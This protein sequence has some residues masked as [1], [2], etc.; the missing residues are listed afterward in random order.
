MKKLM[1]TGLLICMLLIGAKM[2][3]FPIKC[4]KMMI[5]GTEVILIGDRHTGNYPGGIKGQERQINEINVMLQEWIKFLSHYGEET[6]FLLEEGS[7][8]PGEDLSPEYSELA[9]K[10]GNSLTFLS[11]F[12]E[13]HPTLGCITFKK[14]DRRTSLSTQF[15]LFEAVMIKVAKDIL[16]EKDP[17]IIIKELSEIKKSRCIDRLPLLLTMTILKES[18]RRLS[19]SKSDRRGSFFLKDFPCM[20]DRTVDS[21]VDRKRRSVSVEQFL[22][23]LRSVVS[24]L[25]H[26]RINLRMSSQYVRLKGYNDFCT[27]TISLLETFLGPEDRKR[28]W[29][30]AI[31]DSIKREQS[32][33]SYIKLNPVCK[34]E[35]IA[36]Y[37][38]LMDIIDAIER[39]VRR[40]VLYAGAE[41]TCNS[42]CDLS[43]TYGEMGRVIEEAGT[44][45]SLPWEDEDFSDDILS[46]DELRR[47]LY[48]NVIKNK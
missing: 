2:H 26:M 38:F 36:D 12:V 20:M 45:I 19:E 4:T 14:A 33:Q 30:S 23:D 16:D 29:F 10:R 39:D 48:S 13:R 9:I 22:N 47:I 17:Q 46:S 11:K 32:F 21:L 3:P 35:F 40:V 18:E 42:R 24:E 7:P 37:G 28:P 43:D 15:L 41:H 5:K 31:V 8:S 25:E 44:R 1:T 27:E 34:L 6:L